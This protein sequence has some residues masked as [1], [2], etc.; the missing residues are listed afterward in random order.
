MTFL[1]S[2]PVPRPRISAADARPAGPVVAET[3][4]APPAKRAEPEVTRSST[5]TP[6]R[7][8]PAASTART[9]SGRGT[10]RPEIQASQ[11]GEWAASEE[12]APG[13]T[14]TEYAAGEPRRP[15]ERAVTTF[16][17]FPAVRPAVKPARASP[18]PSVD[19]TSSRT[20][21]V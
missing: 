18:A 15:G 20:P 14:V 6:A 8:F 5:G 11:R 1:S 19:T 2:A 13:E 17:P 21:P 4:S 3:R 12:T 16:S 10:G 9:A 7:A